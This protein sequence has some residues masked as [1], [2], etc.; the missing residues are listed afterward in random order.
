[1]ISW[2]LSSIVCLIIDHFAH[3]TIFQFFIATCVYAI[4]LKM[5]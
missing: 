2:I 3:W 1:M 5:D 4:F